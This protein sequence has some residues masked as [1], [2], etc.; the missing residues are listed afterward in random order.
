MDMSM[1]GLPPLD[2]ADAAYVK[3]RF[4]P[5]RLLARA[6]GWDVE[7]LQQ[8]MD[9]QRVPKAS[10][11]LPDGTEMVPADYF[12]LI[13]DGSQLD[14]L[15]GR[16]IPRYEAALR[17]LGLTPSDQASSATWEG[18]L[19]G[20]FGACI[21]SVTPEAMALKESLVDSIAG[22][23]AKPRV[24]DRPW[25]DA[26]RDAVSR[27]DELE[28]PFAR[29]DDIRFGSRSSRARSIDDVRARFPHVFAVN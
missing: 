15:R 1:T 24:D 26:L 18:Y 3:A 10:Y 8:A 12:C 2:S 27:L 20:Q 28:M 7:A 5:L 9:A 25:R 11:V 29:W 21:K 13:G 16:F 17:R 22:L 23:V 4:I 6:N 19:S 14:T